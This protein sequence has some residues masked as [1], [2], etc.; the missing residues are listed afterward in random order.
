MICFRILLNQ[1]FPFLIGCV[2]VFQGKSGHWIVNTK[3]YA[4]LMTMETKGLVGPRL[5][6]RAWNLDLGSK[7][8]PG[9]CKEMDL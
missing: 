5:E 3:K 1:S 4:S 7:L 8:R 9:T 2:L 6:F